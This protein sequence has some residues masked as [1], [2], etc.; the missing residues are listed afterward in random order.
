[1]AYWHNK[2]AIVTGGTSGFG[3]VLALELARRNAKVMLFA[4]D[5]KRLDEVA[6]WL[7]SETNA[8]LHCCSVDVTNEGEVHQAISECRERFQKIDAVFNCVG[9]ST[10]E[11]VLDATPETIESYIAVNLN[12]VVAMTRATIEDL[13]A[14]RGHL[15]NIGSLASKTAWPFVASYAISKSAMATYTH[16]LRLEGP[17]SVHYM[18]VCPG[19]IRR[20]DTG[21]RYD[22][23]AEGLP[24][25]VRQ[26]GAGAKLKGL[27]PEKLARKIL[28]GCEKRRRELIVPAYARIAFIA[29][30][31]SPML[32]DWLLRK[33]MKS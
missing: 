5:Q 13:E 11:K 28:R 23:E 27:D 2:V 12:S 10:R 18:L 14:S 24:D 15:V 26:G 3:K 33:K 6:E 29:S 25:H 16:Q 1:M 17:Q 21:S 20:S 8:D 30:A 9:K 4:R 31:I 22:S 32:G 19:P 7:K